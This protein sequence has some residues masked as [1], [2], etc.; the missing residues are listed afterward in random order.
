MFS[1]GIST[2]PEHSQDSYYYWLWDLDALHGQWL[3]FIFSGH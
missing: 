2:L 3:Y 1:H